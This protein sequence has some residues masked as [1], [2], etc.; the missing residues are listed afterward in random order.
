MDDSQILE[1]IL[2]RDPQGL[3]MLEARYGSYIRYIVRG[4]LSGYPEEIEECVNDLWLKLWDILPGYDNE[5]ASL[6]TYI[7]RIVRNAAL[8]RKK[9]L[10]RRNSHLEM[11]EWREETG[12]PESPMNPGGNPTEEIILQKEQQEQLSRALRT[13]SNKD[14]DLFLRKYYYLQT[15]EQIASETGHSRRAVESRLARIKKKLAAVLKEV[16]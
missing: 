3:T 5:K 16:R 7:S 12:Q 11:G 15:A 13:L 4:I 8:D 10:D 2:A 1:R 9:A 14:M 6:K